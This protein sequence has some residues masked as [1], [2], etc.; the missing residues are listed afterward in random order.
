MKPDYYAPTSLADAFGVLSQANGK[1]VLAAGATDLMLALRSHERKPA[2]VID[3]SR[4]G[5]DAIRQADGEIILGACV[6]HTQLIQSPLVQAHLPALAAACSTIGGPPVRNRGTL[7]GN[8]ANGSPAADSA[9]PL[10]AYDAWLGLASAAGIRQVGLADFF[11]APRQTILG[12]DEVILEIH[13]PLPAGR[14]GAHFIK[15]GKRNAMAVAVVSVAVRLTLDEWGRI[16]T[17]RI[18]LGSVAPIPL[19]ANAAEAAVQG[20]PI[21]E[22]RIAQAAALAP[23]AAS[24]ISDVRASAAYRSQMVAVLTRRALTAARERLER[25]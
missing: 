2:L 23:Q 12:A 3:L 17:A 11:L 8:L 19:R 14:T 5:L 21:V 1:A 10:L 22:A 13:V 16:E 4:L 6:T 24:P 20:A 7:G 25:S 15:L 18:A 9:P